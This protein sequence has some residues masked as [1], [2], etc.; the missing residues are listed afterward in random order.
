MGKGMIIETV[1]VAEAVRLGII[2]MVVTIIIVRSRRR[3]RNSTRNMGR[4]KE[5]M[6]NNNEEGK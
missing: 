6:K 3:G 1:A 4:R 2:T 5:I